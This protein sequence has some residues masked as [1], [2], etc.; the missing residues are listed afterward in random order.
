MLKLIEFVCAA[1]SLIRF[2]KIAALKV[3]NGEQSNAFRL[4]Q[5]ETRL[6]LQSPKT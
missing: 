4:V 3:N 6:N 1:L 5:N 2:C